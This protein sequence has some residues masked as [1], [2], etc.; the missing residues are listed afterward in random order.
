[1]CRSTVILLKL[2]I[3][4]YINHIAEPTRT[5]GGG[6]YAFDNTFAEDEPWYRPPRITLEFNLLYRWHSM[7]PSE[8]KFGEHTYS[9]SEFRLN[10]EPLMEN[11]LGMLLNLLAAE[12]A[13][14]KM[15]RDY[16]VATFN[17]YRERFGLLPIRTFSELTEDKE[18]IKQ[19]K[20]RYKDI[21][22]VEFLVGL[23]AED[24]NLAS[25]MF[26]SLM[27]TMLGF[28]AFTQT[29]TNPLLSENVFNVN[30]FT[31]WGMEEISGT[32]T[33]FDMWSRNGGKNSPNVT[34]SM[35][36]KSSDVGAHIA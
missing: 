32:D 9:F 16:K 15:S 28:D 35:K 24:P 18:V 5:D 27:T 20:E 14:L 17:D 36:L 6:R 33:L 23:Y 1:M 10:N 31:Q 21:N 30:T 8:Y 12:H 22:E 7:V 19:L 34:V 3:E 4:E 11:G 2:V 26:G 29:L 25:G 13:A